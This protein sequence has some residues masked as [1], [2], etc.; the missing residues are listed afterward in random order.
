MVTLS[1]IS[2]PICPWCY[3]GKSYLDAALAQRP[4]H[5]FEI[6]WRPYQLNPDMPKEGIDRRAYLEGKFGGP[7]GVLKAY[8]PVV[9]LAEAAGIELNLPAIKRTP[10]TID[11]H[12][13]IHW[14]GIEGEQNAIVDAL[15]RANFV[16]GRDISDHNVLFE[17][18]GANGVDP[19]MV[20]RL[21]SSEADLEEVRAQ[22][23][24]AREMGVSAVPTYIIAENHVVPGSQPADFWVRIIDEIEENAAKEA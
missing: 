2:D 13:L 4:A 23:E 5:R 3:I 12:R 6:E 17:I 1:I 16:E 14:A 8:A 15:F 19:L 7:E 9:E 24:Q 10:N 21:L 11:A 18:A 22:D 20:Q